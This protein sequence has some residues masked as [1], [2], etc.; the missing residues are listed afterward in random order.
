MNLLV[1]D[2]LV[3]AAAFGGLGLVIN[4]ARVSA[5]RALLVPVRVR[6]TGSDRTTAQ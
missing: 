6:R 2:V 3:V 4:L 5:D 1:L